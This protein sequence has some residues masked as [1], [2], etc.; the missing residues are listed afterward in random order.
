MY[1]SSRKKYLMRNTRY[2]EQVNERAKEILNACH[3]DGRATDLWSVHALMPHNPEPDIIVEIILT[4]LW[5][6]SNADANKLLGGPFEILPAMLLLCRWENQLSK[7]AIGLLKEF[8]TLAHLERGNTENHWLMAYSGILLATER[9]PD[10]NYQWS[11]LSSKAI[12]AEAKRWING[13]INRTAIKG[14]HEY[15]ST[16]YHIEHMTAYI[17][18]YEHTKD[19][20]LRSN[21]EKMLTLLVADMALEFFYGAWAGG[22]SREGYRQN[23]WS[24]LGGILPLQYMYFGGIAFDRINHVHNFAIPAVVADYRPSPL[25]AEMAW[26]RKTAHVVKKT[27]APRTI[28]R[29]AKTDA[30]PIRKYTYMSNNFALGS[31]QTGLPG[32]KAGPIDLV[33]WDLTWN[34]PNHQGIIVCNHPYNS[35]DRFS[36]FLNGFPQHIGRSISSDKPYLQWPDRLFGA[37]PYEQMLQS[38]GSIVVLYD[39]PEDDAHPFVNLFLPNKYSWLQRNGWLF[40]NINSFFIS[41]LPIGEYE[42]TTIR[43][44]NNSNILVR[45]GDLI[46]G[47]LLRLKTYRPGL[48][49]EAIE[50]DKVKSY[51]SFVEKRSY[52]SPS[53]EEWRQNK[54]L[55]VKTTTG[56]TLDITHGGQH[57]INGKPVDYNYDLYEAPGVSAPLNKGIIQFQNKYHSVKLD[58]G[59][60]S[61]QPL[62]PMRVIG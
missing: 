23:T 28:Y 1:P 16:G 18:L 9:W 12:A 59:I 46:D 11:G 4:S 37:S 57:L 17:G 8:M 29:N 22:H 40:A 35:P 62:I 32:N 31:T 21:V 49:L 3:R 10:E 30:T 61:N 34:A 51:E 38:E 15:D 54:R 45:E 5:R 42:W 43:E 44:A 7:K 52:L 20:S 39:L 56:Q 33:S 6:G 60:D 14:H 48:I 47:W 27:K 41:L 13:I 24:Q 36:S 58:F 26:D 50:A 19:S 53:L 25:F 55:E 2:H